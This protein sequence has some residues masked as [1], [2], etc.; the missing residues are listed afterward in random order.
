MSWFGKIMG[1]GVGFMLGGPLGALIGA[2]LGHALVDEKVRIE[3]AE[4]GP[5][6]GVE[7]RQAVFFTALFAMLGKIAK[8]DGRVCEK[9]IAAVRSFMNEQLRLPAAAQQFAIGVFNEAKDT[10]TPFE[11]YARQLGRVFA[12]NA[13]LRTM[14][15]Q[16]LFSIAMV[17][18]VLHPAEE[19]LLR[20]A[21]GPLGLHPDI[22]DTV[23]RQFGHDLSHHYAVLGLENGAGLAEVK[24]SYRKLAAEY[25]PDKV[26][27][28]GL[29]EDFTRF[30]EQ[31]FKEINEAY[32]VITKT[33]AK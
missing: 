30:A 12:D 26:V 27:S 10:D 32:A 6:S 29:P 15:Y 9:E 20:A 5:M 33:A 24:K 4:S 21:P 1:G 23:R 28:K 8:A 2:T 25:H 31:K 11:D 16:L 17:D 3:R 22:F 18:G 7:Q 19:A 14:F 13:P